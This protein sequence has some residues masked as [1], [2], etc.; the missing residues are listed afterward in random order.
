MPDGPTMQPLLNRLTQQSGL[1]SLGVAD[2]AGFV[3]DVSGRITSQ[4][5]EIKHLRTAMQEVACDNASVAV[6]SEQAR[7]HAQGAR[8]DMED[9]HG[10]L[11]QAV[12]AIVSLADVLSAMGQDGA[13]LEQA[14]GSIDKAAR[15][16]AKVA[17]QT[18]LLA[19]NAAI[20]AARAGEAG[21]GFAVV[22]SEV[23]LLAADTAAATEAIRRTVATVGSSARA[24]ISRAQRSTDEAT[25][26]RA[27]G[28]G[29]LQMVDDNRVRMAEING[30]ADHIAQRTRTIS[31]QCDS[32]GQSVES[33]S[34]DMQRSNTDL[35]RAR[36]T[37][38]D[39]L[40]ASEDIAAAGV[41][42]GF[43]TDD[44]PFLAQVRLEAVRVEAVF[45]AEV[46]T[47]RISLVDLF[48]EDYV[49]IAGTN[50]PQHLTR[51]TEMTDRVVRARLEKVQATHNNT[52]FCIIID[53]N[54]YVPTHST[55]LSQ[56]QSADPAWN[57]LF[58]RNRR[59]YRERPIARASRNRKPF[60]LQS[61][62]RLME[63][64]VY[65]PIKVASAPIQF[66][67]RHWG[68]LA[69]AYKPADGGD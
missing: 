16:I 45:E 59:I 69:M 1:L 17:A 62:S 18:K 25:K 63:A 46:A 61:Y 64:G 21:R 39:L 66:Q 34:G 19:L 6:A 40:T 4:V 50:P 27:Q 8:S 52:I 12:G 51:F 3:D 22:A 49:Q 9:C 10:S 24:L 41:N 32:V 58:C 44:T 29:V 43:E 26:L 28:G 23:K 11:E 48:D 54:G 2:V 20:E 68:A 13:L 57:R 47:G 42:A 14:L 5:D 56:P 31:R 30:M 35:R 33:M 53:R 36:D 15:Q 67:G 60:M 37:I 7:Q 55:A 38:L 65:M